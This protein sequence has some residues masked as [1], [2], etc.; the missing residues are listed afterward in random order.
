MI[1]EVTEE[2]V[3]H[4]CM[5]H[6][7][8]INQWKTRWEWGNKANPNEQ[9]QMRIPRYLKILKLVSKMRV[10]AFEYVERRKAQGMRNVTCEFCVMQW[11]YIQRMI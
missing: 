1:M 11:K 5:K 3:K 8:V 4:W 7:L 6:Y 2:A 9:S 10:G